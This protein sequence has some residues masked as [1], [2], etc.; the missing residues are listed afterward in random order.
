MCDSFNLEDPIN[1]HTFMHEVFHGLDTAEKTVIEDGEQIKYVYNGY[2]TLLANQDD[3]YVPINVG[4]SMIEALDEF[5]TVMSENKDSEL[6]PKELI[7]YG[8]DGNTLESIY[9]ESAELLK[10]WMI[11]MD[12]TYPE[13]INTNTALFLYNAMKEHGVYNGIDIIQMEDTNITMKQYGDQPAFSFGEIAGDFWHGYIVNILQQNDVHSKKEAQAVL[14]KERDS[15]DKAIENCIFLDT[16]LKE[17]MD[18][19]IE[20]IIND[21]FCIEN[22]RKNNTED[23]VL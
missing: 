20:T 14:E 15:I 8:N 4:M 7:L 3:A 13:L 16:D 10:E 12:I 18:N 19:Y 22:I 21:Y 1:E 5:I 9:V 17:I 2:I 23:Y 11:G 6:Y